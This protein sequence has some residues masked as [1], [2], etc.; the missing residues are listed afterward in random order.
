MNKL[1]PEVAVVVSYQGIKQNAHG[2]FKNIIHPCITFPFSFWEGKFY[3][4]QEKKYDL[5]AQKAQYMC[6]DLNKHPLYVWDI[7]LTSISSSP[8]K[9]NHT[10]HYQMT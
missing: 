1:L 7:S 3:Y 8:N 2:Q 5:D 4:Y 6:L 9:E 10:R